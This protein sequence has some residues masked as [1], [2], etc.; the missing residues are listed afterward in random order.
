MYKCDICSYIYDSEV[1]DPENGIAAGVDLKDL[2]ESWIC[3]LCGIGTEHF[4]PLENG[5]LIPQREAPLS[6]MMMALTRSLWQICGR[7][8]C[9][10][11]REIG[12]LFIKQLKNSDKLKNEEEA[13]K[14]VKEYF[15]DSNKFALDMEYIIKEQEVEVEIKNCGFFGLCSQ[16][17]DQKVLISTCPYSN[18]IAAAMEEVTGYRHRISKEQKG[19][20]HKIFLKRVSKIK[21]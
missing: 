9:A 18:T 19:Y 7:G 2:P 21:T 8:S 3:P 6:L 11:T 15:I 20:G 10:V 1:G 16:L 12:R 5:A 14:S 13:L 4:H 17:E